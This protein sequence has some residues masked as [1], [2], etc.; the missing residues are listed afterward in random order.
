MKTFFRLTRRVLLAGLVCVGVLTGCSDED[1]SGNGVS[2]ITSADPSHGYMLNSTP[3]HLQIDL[4]EKE[5]FEL[6]LNPGMLIE[7]KLD[8]NRTYVLHVVV[9]NAA[10]R[11]VSEYVNTFYIDD[12]PLDN[13]LNDFVCSWYVE[14]TPTY[15]EYGFANNF[16]T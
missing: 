8:T 1:D 13:Q 9:M 2:A 12:I 11:A 3:Y 15:P 7:M 14:F 4:G 16:G 6:S 10:N 5:K